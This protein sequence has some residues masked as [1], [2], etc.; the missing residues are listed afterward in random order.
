MSAIVKRR[1]ACALLAL[2]VLFTAGGLH[3]LAHLE[4]DGH[5]PTPAPL[6]AAGGPDEA[7]GGD[8]EHHPSQPAHPAHDCPTCKHG[9]TATIA[10]P[11]GAPC[12]AQPACGLPSAR[13]VRAPLAQLLLTSGLGA[14][15]PPV[16]FA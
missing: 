16:A 3:E 11:R 2:A 7:H 6:A 9:G 1:L 14:R 4:F 8:C 15:A 5:G 13:D 12:V 10:P